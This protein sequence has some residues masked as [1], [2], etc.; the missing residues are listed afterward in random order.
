MSPNREE[1]DKLD[2]RLATLMGA[3]QEGNAQA[4]RDLLHQL[5]E[6]LR[7]VVKSR[8]SFLA[9]QDVEDIVQEILLSIHSVRAT[10]DPQ[11]PF[12][13][14]L[15]AIAR[16]RLA[17]SARRY[18]RVGRHETLVDELPVTFVDENTNIGVDGYKD[19]ELL[20]LAIEKLP[21]TERRAVELLKIK[22]LSLK[23]ASRQ[24]G[25]SIQS[26]K[27]SVHRGVSNL[28]KLMLKQESDHEN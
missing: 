5:T 14:W 10:Y 17:D 12:L 26:L 15:Y 7:R 11:R 1:Y 27:V 8:R 16:N 23:E 28:R 13:P 25:L 21:A 4:Y 20:R 22:E 19:P 24:T 3:A 9:S 2:R 6:Y 18:A